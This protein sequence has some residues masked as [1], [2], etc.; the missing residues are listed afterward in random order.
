[1]KAHNGAQSVL[2]IIVRLVFVNSLSLRVK[3]VSGLYA[4]KA[5]L[6]FSIALKQVLVSAYPV[7]C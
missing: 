5:N 1:M 6:A 3:S 7:K 2:P 4:I